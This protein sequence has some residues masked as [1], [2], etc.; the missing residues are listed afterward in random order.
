[1]QVCDEARQAIVE[2]RTNR[3]DTKCSTGK[4][5]DQPFGTFKLNAFQMN[6]WNGRSDI[7]AFSVVNSVGKLSGSA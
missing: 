1:V 3:F 5:S 7:F 2:K 4:P 6:K